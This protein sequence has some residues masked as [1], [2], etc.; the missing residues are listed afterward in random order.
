MQAEMDLSNAVAVTMMR[1]N[2]RY[3]W[4]QEGMIMMMKKKMAGRK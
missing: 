4:P 3:D 1:S 2:V